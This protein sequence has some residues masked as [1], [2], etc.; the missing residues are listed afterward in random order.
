MTNIQADTRSS[1]LGERRGLKI[2]SCP[3]RMES[4]G[5]GPWAEVKVQ[6]VEVPEDTGRRRL[7]ES[8][9]ARG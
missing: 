2:M 9:G 8:V 7:C 6:D 1:Q 5:E 3:G 4:R